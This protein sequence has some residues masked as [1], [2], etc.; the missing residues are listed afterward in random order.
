MLLFGIISTPK[1]S[2]Q[3]FFFF[4]ENELQPASGYFPWRADKPIL[5][6]SMLKQFPIVDIWLYNKCLF[7]SI[8]LTFN[9]I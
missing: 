1:Q 6:Y 2:L 9:L 4:T 5:L 8:Q 3:F 7:F